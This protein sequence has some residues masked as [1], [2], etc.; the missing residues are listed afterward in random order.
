MIPTTVTRLLTKAVKGPATINSGRTTAF[1][2][3]P[4]IPEAIWYLSLDYIL[5]L[6][7]NGLL[8]YHLYPGP[9]INLHLTQNKF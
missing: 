8:F 6:L 2:V 9:L 4:S 3:I 1:K 7:I 5:A